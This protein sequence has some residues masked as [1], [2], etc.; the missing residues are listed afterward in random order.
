M[1]ILTNI[2]LLKK[3]R[4]K[5]VATLGPAT[6]TSEKIDQLVAAGVD[7]FRLNMSHGS[8]EDH[9]ANLA[10]VRQAA[11]DAK[12]PIAVLADLCG[13]KIR[14]GKFPD[15][16]IDLVPGEEVVVTTREVAG[17]SGLIPS[18]YAALAE[19]VHPG[20]RVLLA[21]GVMELRVESVSGT[22]VICSVIQGGRLTDRKGI[23][24]PDVEVSAP[25]LTDKDRSDAS[26]ILNQDV[27]F[28]AL[29]FVRRRED[30]DQ[31]RTLMS[32]HQ[33]QAALV[34]KIERPEALSYIDGIL[35]A[36]AAIMVARG[37]LGV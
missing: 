30:M 19:D 20:A 15:G 23:N 25:S 35:A 2:A 12:R 5:I 4:T 37:D 26:F 6:N 13:P 11:Q 9:A 29:S 1:A 14:V 32:A 28:L 36:S 3:R 8:H 34:A 17:E 10:R 27:D 24:L 22:E 18:Q 21:D 7:V 31:L 33:R 16:G